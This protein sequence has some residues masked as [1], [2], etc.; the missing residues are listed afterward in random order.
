MSVCLS[1]SVS[2]RE[3]ERCLLIVST[4]LV[5]SSKCPRVLL[6]CDIQTAAL[7]NNLLD[8]L[9]HASQ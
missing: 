3:R 2:E 9:C 5:S 4:G 7:E 1:V 6:S 8:K